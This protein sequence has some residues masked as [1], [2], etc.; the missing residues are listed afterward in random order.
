MKPAETVLE[1]D[2]LWLRRMNQDD[3]ET[4]FVIFGDPITVAH[5]PVP[6][7]RDEVVAGIE[8]TLKRYRDDGYGLWMMVVKDT[9][10]AVGDCGL[11]RQLLPTGPEVEVGYHLRRDHWGRGYATE[12]AARCIAYAFSE[13]RI[14]RV[15]SLIRPSNTPSR[16]VAER[17]GLRPTFEVIWH[18]LPHLV[19]AISRTE[20]EFRS[21]STTQWT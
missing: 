5:F 3:V 4:L 14:E 7:T 21:V 9:G 10:E 1:T 19:Y 20:W 18:D 15:I 2:R 12:A 17:N 13:L 8:R 6:W 11:V 16:R